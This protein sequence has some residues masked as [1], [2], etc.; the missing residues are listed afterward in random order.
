MS[1]TTT[2]KTAPVTRETAHRDGAGVSRRS[3]TELVTSQGRTAIAD[4]VVRKI[5]GVATREVEGVHNLGSGSARAVG[6]LRQRIP[7]SS[8]RNVSQGVGVEVGE[9][10]AA[11]DLDVVVDYGVSIVDLAQAIRGNVVS[12]V[13][14]MTGLEVTE[15]NIAVDDVYI[16]EDDDDKQARVQ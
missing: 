1:T 13:E 8:G 7:G 4:S 11:I 9:R 14:G 12:S 16:P 10:Q 15:V 6:S 5:A 2:E 3:T